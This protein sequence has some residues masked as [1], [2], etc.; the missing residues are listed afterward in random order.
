MHGNLI[1]EPQ[2]YLLPYALPVPV[3]GE[4]LGTNTDWLDAGNI[5]CFKAESVRIIWT[6]SDS[7]ALW[8]FGNGCYFGARYCSSLPRS[9]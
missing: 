3:L 1:Y 2:E 7:V 9:R 4:H 8:A 6:F 5:I